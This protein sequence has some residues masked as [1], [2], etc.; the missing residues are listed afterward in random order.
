M[1]RAR[2]RCV[3]FAA[4]VLLKLSHDRGFRLKKPEVRVPGTDTRVAHDPRAEDP[5]S[6]TQVKRG[7]EVKSGDQAL[8]EAQ[9]QE[10]QLQVS[11]L[12][13]RH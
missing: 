13:V 3:C 8:S 5:T 9:A 4:Y 7:E 10:Q 12:D 1:V 11:R 6:G 2:L